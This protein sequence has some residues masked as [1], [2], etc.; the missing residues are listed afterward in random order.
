LPSSAT[1]SDLSSHLGYWLRFVSNHVSNAFARKVEGLGVTV[2]EWV[3]L[4]Q[5][6]DAEPL[7][8]SLLA[9]LMGATR[10]TVTKLADRLI[11]KALVVRESSSTD[12]RAQFLRLTPAGRKLVP[13]LA[14]LADRNDAEFFDHLSVAEREALARTLRDIVER[15]GLSS[16]PVD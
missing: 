1:P 2:A 15:R 9:D 12:G 13:K 7:S 10:G 8:P 5:L 14:L 16:L 6:L 3:L 11:A 4:R